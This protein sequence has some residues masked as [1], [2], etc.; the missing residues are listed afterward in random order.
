MVYGCVGF[1]V[2]RFLFGV[3]DLGLRA[4]GQRFRV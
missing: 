4:L 2:K 1:R 3:E